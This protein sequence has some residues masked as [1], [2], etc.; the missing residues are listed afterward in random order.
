MLQK[1]LKKYRLVEIKM[2]PHCSCQRIQYCNKFFLLFFKRKSRN[3]CSLASCRKLCKTPEA[4]VI[5]P[6]VTFT[7]L[8][9]ARN[10]IIIGNHRKPQVFCATNVNKF[11]F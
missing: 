1:K 9:S 7:D 4:V 11:S 6:F 8:L 2:C 5:L 3:F 10:K